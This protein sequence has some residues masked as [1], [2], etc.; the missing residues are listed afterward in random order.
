[1]ISKNIKFKYF[2]QGIKNGLNVKAS[3]FKKVKWFT[4]YPL[5]L[6]LTSKYKNSY[7]RSLVK[8]Y[9]K[10]ENF[11]ILGMGGSILGTEAIYQFLKHKIKKNF[12]LLI[13]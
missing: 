11:R 6:S 5:L 13:I 3:N 10:S 8:K 7:D 9:K 2:S 4:K 1:M 12:I